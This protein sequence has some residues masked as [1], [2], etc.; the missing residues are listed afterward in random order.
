[1]AVLDEELHRHILRV[2][3]CHL[4]LEAVVAHDGGREDDG[5]VLGGHLREREKKG[6]VVVIPS[7]MFK[8]KTKTHQILPFSAGHPDKVEHEELEAVAM[9]GRE[10]VDCLSQVPAALV[11]ALQHYKLK[12]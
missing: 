2:H 7:K 4:L 5:Q 10:H 12:R 6:L 8:S 11:F 9:L 3:V 1:M